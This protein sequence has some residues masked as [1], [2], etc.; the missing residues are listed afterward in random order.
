MQPPCPCRSACLV[1]A[2]PAPHADHRPDRLPDGGRS[3]RDPGDP[4]GARARLRRHA[5]GDGLCGQRQHHRHGGR[6]TRRRLLRPPHRSRAAASSRACALLAIPTA[7]LA[8]GAG[9]RHLHAAAHRAGPVHVDR[10]HADPRLSRRA[11]QRRATRPAPSPPTS[12]ATSRAICSAGWSPRRSPT[13]FG[14]AANFLVLAALNLAGAVLVCVLR[15]TARRRCAHAGMQP[16]SPFASLAAH[17]RNPA[18]ARE[19][20]PSAFCILFAFIGTFTY[21][22]F[23]L[24][25]APLGLDQMALGFVYFVFLPSIVTTPLAGRVGRPLRHA[26]RPS[27]AR[28]ARRRR[29]AA[30][31]LLPSL[32]A[33]LAGLALVGVGT[34]FAQATATGFVGRAATTD[35]GSAS[36][37]YLASL[38]LRRPGRQRRA[39]PG[40]RPA[41]AGP[42]ASSASALALA[43]AALLSLR[44]HV[45]PERSI[46]RAPRSQHSTSRPQGDRHDHQRQGSRRAERAHARRQGRRRDR[47]DE[48]HRPRHRPRTRR[49]RRRRSCSTASA[50]RRHRATTTSGSPAST[51]SRCVYSPRRHGEAG[52]R[53][54]RWST[55]TL[56][57]FGA[58]RHPRQQCRHPA[59]RADRE[60]P[61]REVGRDHRDQPVLRLPHDAPRA[62]CDA[63]DEGGAGS[64]TSPRRM[65]SSPRPSRRPTSPPSTAWS[66]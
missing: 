24:V 46:H 42:P 59:C 57:T 4:A 3:L 36:G 56:E 38:L 66:A 55:T 50:R 45:M 11:L 13:I 60:V 6:R 9:P 28:F 23:V 31:A 52:A 51:A 30:A 53:S 37:L 64:S 58:A 25:R 33:V 32:P 49:G 29:R 39:R 34:F 47:L 16:G 2:R 8:V 62:A 26:A 17:L 18:A 35:R 14:L 20:S 5:G 63:P 43:V 22:N 48:R 1:R 12:P 61:A 19:P 27:G 21:V 10:L 41:A 44:L 54:Q 7:L 40:L 65:A 15:S